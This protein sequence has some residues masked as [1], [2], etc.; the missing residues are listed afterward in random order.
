MFSDLGSPTASFGLNRSFASRTASPKSFH[1]SSVV[2]APTLVLP[3]EPP[4][5][6]ERN[7][8]PTNSTS[9]LPPINTKTTDFESL[10]GKY[11]L[12][13]PMPIVSFVVQGRLFK[14]HR[15]FLERDSLFLRGA[16][17]TVQG[18]QGQPIQLHGV[19]SREFESLLDFL[20]EGMYRSGADTVPVSEWLN[21]LAAASALKFDR[22]R[23]HAIAAIDNSSE[24][25][26]A[27][28]MMILAEKYGI[29][30]WLRPAYILMCKR[31]EPLRLSEAE[32]IG[33]DKVV[34]LTQ[35]REALLRESLGVNGLR[36][37]SP[38]P[39]PYPWPPSNQT[40]GFIARTPTPTL[41]VEEAARI[42]DK[43]FFTSDMN[44]ID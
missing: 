23:E 26:D 36:A 3:L 39:S 33:L 25:P 34:K 32:R 18:V 30:K 35:A 4:S 44:V 10:R 29:T 13:H 17:S 12:D 14:V 15:Y 16:L 8:K 5:N 20:Y 21:L 41:A 38:L 19:S 11:Y 7:H 6:P 37:V 9:V 27:I 40:Q 31:A 1:F 24:R 43:I 22:A 42:V 28:E 2:G